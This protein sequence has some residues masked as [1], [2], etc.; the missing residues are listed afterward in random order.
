[1]KYLINNGGNGTSM[2]STPS[3]RNILVC[4]LV[5]QLIQAEVRRFPVTEQG[6]AYI[7][8]CIEHWKTLAATRP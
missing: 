3:A 4:D 2:Q 5:D 1:M 7:K 8:A 6:K